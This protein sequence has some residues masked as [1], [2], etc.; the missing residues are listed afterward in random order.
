MGLFGKLFEKKVCAF[1]GGEIGLLGNR[2]LEDGNMCKNCA[3]KLS[4]FF[5]DRRNSTVAEI[6]EQLEY[7]EANKDAVAAFHTTLSLGN[8]TKILFDEDAGKFI[9]TS[10]RK[11]MEEN[12][13]VLDFSMVTGVD[14]DID[15]E[16]DE[17]MTE[18]KEGNEVSYKP[19][20]YNYS[21]DF[22]VTI[23][24]NHPYFDEIRFQLN[25]SSIVTTE[26]SGAVIAVRKPDP[27]RNMEYRECLEMGNEIKEILT[28]GR[29]KVREEAAAAA[30][31]KTAVKCP[32]C[33]A[34]TIPDNSGC[35]EYCGAAL[36]G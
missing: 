4:P 29:R 20:R 18:D 25:D 10:E 23:R 22:C 24:V 2:K 5:S 34:S 12:P 27:Q 8:S 7:R 30:A 21:Y 6:G 26:N 13:D 36:N 33:G 35:C 14:V 17:E 16:C 28:T 32:F 9:V 19:P 1:C 11:L 31:P 15:E 3:S